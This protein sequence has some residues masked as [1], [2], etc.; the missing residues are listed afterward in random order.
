M[1]RE[2]KEGATMTP[3][4]PARVPVVVRL[5]KMNGRRGR[6]TTFDT[7]VA[8]LERALGQLLAICRQKP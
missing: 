7:V 4:A 1:W 5:E 3:P 8:T 2:W 6:A